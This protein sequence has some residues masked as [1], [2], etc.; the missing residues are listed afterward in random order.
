MS[1]LRPAGQIRPAKTFCQLHCVRCPVPGMLCTGLCGPRMKTFG[2][3]VVDEQIN[4]LTVLLNSVLG[5]YNTMLWKYNGGR[6][7]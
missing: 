4:A 6:R 5:E 7:V 1:K 3:P 2:D